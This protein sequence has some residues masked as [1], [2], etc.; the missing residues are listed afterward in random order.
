MRSV[1]SIKSK[2]LLPGSYNTQY[3]TGATVNV[4]G[5]NPTRNF[6]FDIDNSDM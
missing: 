3:V 2:A 4:T 5:Y 6:T 1:E